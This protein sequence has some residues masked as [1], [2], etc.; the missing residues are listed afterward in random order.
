MHKEVVF[1]KDNLAKRNWNGG[2]QCSFCLKD[3]SI[4]HLFYNCYCA[5][6]IWGLIPWDDLPL[7]NFLFAIAIFSG[8][9]FVTTK[10]LIPCMT[11]GYNFLPYMP[12]ISTFFYW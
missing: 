9:L 8:P 6:F 4:Q 5:R 2:K 12:S 11:F 10:M 1:T 3:E 7:V